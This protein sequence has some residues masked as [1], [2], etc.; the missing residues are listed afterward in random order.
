M[1]K[2]RFVLGFLTGA[3]WSSVN[4]LL[5]V[6]ILKI[7]ILHKPKTKLFLI[8]LIKFPLLYLIGF[9]LLISGFFPPLSLLAGLT[10]VLLIVGIMRACPKCKQ[11]TT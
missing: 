7:A 9:W 4:F 1:D 10:F 5:L 2:W 6:N 3:A 11:Q 8:L